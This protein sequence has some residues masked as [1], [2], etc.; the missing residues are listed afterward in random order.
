MLKCKCCH[1]I[2]SS[3]Y[4]NTVTS[5]S[6]SSKL[7]ISTNTASV[8]G[9]SYIDS[10]L[11]GGSRW[12]WT[13]GDPSALSYYFGGVTQNHAG[14]VALNGGNLTTTTWTDAEKSAL[15]VGLQKWTDL[16]GMPIEEVQDENDADLRWF[17]TTE[18]AGYYG[19]HFGPHSA[20]HQGIGIFVR[21][22]GVTWTTS[23][24]PGGFG[25]ITIIHELGH[26]LGLAHPHDAGGGSSNFPGVSNY[27][28]TGNF[29]LNQN[30]FTVM[31]YNDLNS[32]FNPTSKKNYGFCSGPMA[33][34]IAAIEYLYG[35]SSQFK[36]GDNIYT[37]TDGTTQ[38]VDMYT[39]VYDTSGNDMLI[40]N[41]SQKVTIDL[42]AASIQDVPD[43]GGYVSKVDS[44]SI[45]SGFTISKDVQI[46]NATGGSNNDTIYQVETISNLIDGRN[47][48]DTVV[49]QFIFSEYTLLD[50]G[51]DS[52]NNHVIHVT[53]NN[54]T[55]ILNNIETLQFLDGTVNTSDLQTLVSVSS[56]YAIYYSD[57]TLP[58]IQIN[59]TTTTITNDIVIAISDAHPVFE[60]QVNINELYH[61][62]VGDIT[63]TLTH[64]TTGTSVLLMD[65]PGS[66]VNGSS[67]NNFINTLFTDSASQTIQTVSSSAAPHT[68]SYKP[69]SS[70]S[71]FNSKSINGTWRLTITD[72]YPS[73]DDGLLVKWSIRCRP[74]VAN[75]WVFVINNQKDVIG[76]QTAGES[77]K[78][79]LHVLSNESAYQTTTVIVTA[80]HVTNI[81][82]WVF[83]MD[84]ENNLYIIKLNQT[85][86]NKTEMH[87]LSAASNYQRY[88]LHRATALHMISNP[89]AWRFTINNNKDLVIIKLQQTGSN[90]TE[91]HILSAASS[92]KQFTLHKVTSLHM[93]NYINW[94]F[95][96][97]NQ[98]NLY[99]FKLNQTGSNQTEIHVLSKDSQY[100]TFIRHLA[101]SFQQIDSIRWG[102]Q[103]DKDNN[104]MII[105]YCGD[106]NY[107]EL[108]ELSATSVYKTFLMNNVITTL[109]C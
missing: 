42:R 103:I 6:S 4:Q 10:L 60:L 43:G 68:G 48:I 51:F 88:I 62:W 25:F 108:Y 67:G 35:L 21:Y 96:F 56:N 2:G 16:I 95:M 19:A 82:N 89:H 52:S 39:C 92:Y 79:E 40:Y 72:T 13:Q 32:D 90:K 66:G 97:N 37:I 30:T 100:K 36:S 93:T 29:G 1:N 50:Q 106:S 61:T 81:Y 99:V 27:S 22:S 63:I 33:F 64:I 105:K 107:T 18:N 3:I 78:T 98:N 20:P 8:S 87:I 77:N 17:I 44:Q 24:D 15:V 102:L 14:V 31:S 9:N 38:G 49:Y 53:K 12:D 109:S 76:I 75:S 54:I 65:T 46:E 5:L 26:A 57:I 47:G 45:Y 59:N 83:V 86:S 94:N 101:S 55:D 71:A 85:G 104:L 34:D 91:V 23:L 73:E 84:N 69:H 11:W 70:L 28:D 80:L 41:G 58:G 74:K 7:N